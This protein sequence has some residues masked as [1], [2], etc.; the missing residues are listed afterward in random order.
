MD[1]KNFDKALEILKDQFSHVA[2]ETR[3][4]DLWRV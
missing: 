3:F 4:P 2:T 1:K